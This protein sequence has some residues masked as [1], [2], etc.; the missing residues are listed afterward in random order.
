MIVTEERTSTIEF[1]SRFKHIDYFENSKVIVVAFES[2]KEACLFYDAI[3]SKYITMFEVEKCI[4]AV[5]LKARD[6]AIV[7]KV[8]TDA[9]LSWLS[10]SLNYS[11]SF[12]N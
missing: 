4:Y 1:R 10:I 6:G 9:I 8:T 2:P 11:C 12:A 7:T 3:V 5:M